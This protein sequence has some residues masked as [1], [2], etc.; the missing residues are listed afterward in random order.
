MIVLVKDH[1]LCYDY[2]HDDE[3]GIAR[4]SSPYLISYGT[5]TRNC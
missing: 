2:S 5:V 3:A 1:D 4:L